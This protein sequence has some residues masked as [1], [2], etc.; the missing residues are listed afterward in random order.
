MTAPDGTHHQNDA[1][2]I[3]VLK[4]AAA[5]LRQQLDPPGCCVEHKRLGVAA[6]PQRGP[7]PVGEVAAAVRTA[8]QR[9]A[10]RVTTGREVIELRPDG[11]WD[12]GKTLLWVLDHLPHSGS[13]LVPTTSATTSPTRTLWSAPW[14]TWCATPTTVTAPPPPCL[15]WTVPHGSRSSPIGWRVSS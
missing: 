13:A 8:E 2:A 10:L 3:P 4:Q 12:K 9:H 11:D 5:E 1:A 6:L 7:E 15:R 14:C